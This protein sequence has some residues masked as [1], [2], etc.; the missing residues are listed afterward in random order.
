MQEAIYMQKMMRGDHLTEEMRQQLAA[1][2]AERLM[3][4]MD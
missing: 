1:S 4:F 3:D 2:K